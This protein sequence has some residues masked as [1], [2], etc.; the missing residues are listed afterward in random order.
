MS[1]RTP[2]VVLDVWHQH[3][4]ILNPTYKT[5]KNQDY[6]ESIESKILH[7]M[8]EYIKDCCP[9]FCYKENGV[10]APE[11]LKNIDMM[12]RSLENTYCYRFKKR[13]P[14]DVKKSLHAVS[15]PFDTFQSFHMET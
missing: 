15:Q 3:D 14:N 13:V 4:G 1:H 9:I 11:I 8:Q 2:I 10:S 12:L 5:K 7:D 6:F